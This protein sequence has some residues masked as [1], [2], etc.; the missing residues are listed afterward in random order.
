MQEEGGDIT[1]HS[2]VI[3]VQGG[4]YSALFGPGPL[5]PSGRTAYFTCQFSTSTNASLLTNQGEWNAWTTAG[6]HIGGGS[7]QSSAVDQ[8]SHFTTHVVTVEGSQL[9]LGLSCQHDAWWVWVPDHDE[10]QSAAYCQ[11]C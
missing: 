1:T 2:A 4:S 11:D 9:D 6:G 8:S 5:R 3:T 7:C 10:A